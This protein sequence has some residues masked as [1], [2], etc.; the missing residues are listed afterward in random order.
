MTSLSLLPQTYVSIQW[1][2]LLIFSKKF[3]LQTKNFHYQASIEKLVKGAE[4]NV[5]SL[6]RSANCSLSTV[7]R[8]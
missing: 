1:L 4:I 3:Q 8:E 7:R 6:K 2:I 5:V